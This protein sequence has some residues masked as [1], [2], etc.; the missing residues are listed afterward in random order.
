MLLVEEIEVPRENH[1]LTDIFLTCHGRDLNQ[2]N[3]DGQLAVI[4]KISDKSV[5]RTGQ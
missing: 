1:Q 5:I 3:I 4:G 2:F